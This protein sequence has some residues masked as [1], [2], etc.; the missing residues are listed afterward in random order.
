MTRH[1]AFCRGATAFQSVIQDS[2]AGTTG[3]RLKIAEQ[4][5]TAW[6]VLSPGKSAIPR[7]ALFGY[8]FRYLK[9]DFFG[10]H[11]VLHAMGDWRFAQVPEPVVRWS[12]KRRYK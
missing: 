6:G 7:E 2:E 5:L 9:P 3:F 1:L 12:A 11:E 8:E 10:Y 4:H